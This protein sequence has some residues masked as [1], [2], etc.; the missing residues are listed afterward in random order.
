MQVHFSSLNV[1]SEVDMES[2]L[3]QGSFLDSRYPLLKVYM[4]LYMY[5]CVNLKL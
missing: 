4:K 1:T 3:P 2:V 5:S